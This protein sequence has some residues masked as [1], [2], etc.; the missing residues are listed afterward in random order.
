MYLP[1]VHQLSDEE[2]Q[3]VYACKR[4][5]HLGVAVSGA[6]SPGMPLAVERVEG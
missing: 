2:P 5:D 3:Y 4:Y 1:A 6:A